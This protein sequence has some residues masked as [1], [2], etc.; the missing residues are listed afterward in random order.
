MLVQTLSVALKYVY[1]RIFTIIDGFSVIIHVQYAVPDGIR[2]REFAY[3][4]AT[5]R[6][7]NALLSRCVTLLPV[8]CTVRVGLMWLKYL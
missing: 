5:R 7:L 1:D 6:V 2:Q 3:S 8:T 4:D